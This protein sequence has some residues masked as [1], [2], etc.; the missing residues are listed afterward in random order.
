[1][2]APVQLSAS[3][4]KMSVERGNAII[5]VEASADRLVESLGGSPGCFRE[6]PPNLAAAYLSALFILSTQKPGKTP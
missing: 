4:L 5:N 3:A 1:M 2:A 6:L